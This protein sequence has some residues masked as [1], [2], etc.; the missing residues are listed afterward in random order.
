MKK[1]FKILFLIIA[2]F[3]VVA[4]DNKIDSLVKDTKKEVA[5]NIENTSKEKI[6]ESIQYIHDNYEKKISKK[7][8]YHTI[9]LKRLCD[10]SHL[11]ES[12]IKRLADASY[13]Y[14]FSQSVGN[15]KELKESINIVYDNLDKEI[16]N[17]YT[18]YQRLI[19]VEGYLAKAK[20]KLLVEADEKDFIS[21]NNI[22]KAID[23]IQ[24]YYDNA[25]KN[26][27][28]IERLCYYSMYLEQVGNKVKKQNSIT[29]L[30]KSMKKHMQ[31]GEVKKTEDITKLLNDI[32]NNREAL[33]GEL[34]AR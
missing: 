2:M 28:V 23:Y 15:K 5:S 3:F 32:K 11:S 12:K 33:I 34:M 20:T 9:L 14:M 17:F 27:E 4:C 21:N 18:I 26:N 10:N 31:S 6:K 13:E 16:D 1:K 22:V 8:V 30:G 24:D 7:Y 29:N 25:F 19:V